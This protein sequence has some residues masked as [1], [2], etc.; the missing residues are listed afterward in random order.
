MRKTIKKG[1]LVGFSLLF[2]LSYSMAQT[3][4]DNGIYYNITSETDL[5]LEV[6][7]PTTSDYTYYNGSMT[8]PESVEYNGVTYAVT[9]IADN[10]FYWCNLL[11]AINI[12]NTV[13]YIGESAFHDCYA[14]QS[15]VLGN[16]VETIGDEAFAYCFNLTSISLPKS[17]KS[18]GYAVF[19]ESTSLSEINVEEGCENY[20]SDEHG[21]LFNGDKTSLIQY[22]ANSKLSSYD[23]PNTV[24]SIEDYAFYWSNGLKEINMGNSVRTIGDMAFYYCTGLRAIDLPQTLTYI[25]EEAFYNCNK[26]T[27]LEIPDLVTSISNGTFSLCKGLTSV[28]I[29]N[30][31][32]SIGE[33]AFGW[34]SGLKTVEIGSSVET[35]GEEAFYECTSIEK[36]IVSEDNQYYSSDEYGVFFNKDKTT[37]IQY[38][39]G[40]TALSYEIPE[41]VENLADF[42]F[43]SCSYLTTV[44]FPASVTT[45]GYEVFCACKALVSVVLPSSLTSLSES[46]FWECSALE[47]VVIPASVTYIYDYAFA[48]CSSLVSITSLNPEPPVCEDTDVFFDVD[49]N[50]CILS[51]PEGA[52]DAYSGAYVWSEFNNINE[53]ENTG[54]NGIVTNGHDVISKRYTLDGKLV[55]DAHKGINI[56]RYDDGSIKK[57]MIK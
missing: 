19:H 13:T 12:A 23:I 33:G 2:A 56:I 6:I 27:S 44:D 42:S 51:V 30:S 10:A 36:F 11:E 26:I 37:L 18:L 24:E 20:C 41:T 45:F 46:T 15:V 43:Y 55:N 25:G 50:S 16:A 21:V 38:P 5:T 22:P 4:V 40:S 32:T 34:C 35:I 14:L 52:S 7:A 47:S 31:V 29:G 9:G 49:K 8:I 57:V 48:Y 3:F 1:V 28:K 54:I 53:I 17:L 39:A